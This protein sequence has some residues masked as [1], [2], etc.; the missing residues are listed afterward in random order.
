MDQTARSQRG[1]GGQ[2]GADTEGD[3]ESQPD[4]AAG[5]NVDGNSDSSVSPLSS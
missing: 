3:A 5:E 2:Q 4:A 1:E